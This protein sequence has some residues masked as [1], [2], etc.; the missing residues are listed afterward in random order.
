MSDKPNR[1]IPESPV[2]PD[3]LAELAEAQAA[4][5]ALREELNKARKIGIDTA[6]LEKQLEDAEATIKLIMSVYGTGK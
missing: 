6:A 2:T 3:M 4:L 1:F 5:P